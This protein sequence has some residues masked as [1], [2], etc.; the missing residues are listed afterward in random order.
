MKIAFYNSSD[1]VYRLATGTLLTSGG[2]IKQQWLLAKILVSKGYEV[3][4]YTPTHNSEGLI[5]EIE[6]IRFIQTPLATTNLSLRRLFR[7][8]KPNW[9]Y[10]R[11]NSMHLGPCFLLAKTV[12]ISTVYACA[13]DKDC[14]PKHALNPFSYRK[15]FWPF[16]LWGL[17]LADRI[18]VQHSGQ[19]NLLGPKYA[20][21][22]RI[23]NNIAVI[24]QFQKRSNDKPY[25]IWVGNL[26]FEKRPD[27]LV[28]IAQK[29]PHRNFKVCGAVLDYRSQRGYAQ[30]ISQTLAAL[31][32]VEYL[33]AVSPEE[34]INL[35]GN[36]MLFLST[37]AQEGFPNTMLEAWS[38]GRPVVSLGLDPGSVI[39]T[40]NLGRRTKDVSETILII[41]QL[42]EN[43]S[44][45]SRIGQNC[46]RYI[47]ENH[48]P[49]TVYQQFEN[50]LIN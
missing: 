49:I 24:P 1:G 29:L 4:F 42:L 43:P 22:T 47:I 31:P 38:V 25:I 32:N 35:V 33:G 36:A 23:V 3:I 11:T 6:G 18:L 40:N 28:E 44:E 12:G 9:L 7:E 34:T 45:I 14:D 21:R 26:R 37:S 5:R 30:S 8:E 41:E 19:L 27:L 50:A 46:V 48:S 20:S 16:Y 17:K 39:T 2:A 10:W 15:Y 13:S